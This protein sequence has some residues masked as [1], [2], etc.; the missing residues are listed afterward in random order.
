MDHELLHTLKCQNNS[1]KGDYH[2]CLKVF[3]TPLYFAGLQFFPDMF[4]SG[5]SVDMW[6]LCMYIFIWYWYTEFLFF[7]DYKVP[8]TTAGISKCK[9]YCAKNTK[10]NTF[11]FN[12][13]PKSKNSCILKSKTCKK[14][15]PSPSIYTY[16]RI[17][18]KCKSSI[19]FLYP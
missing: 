16:Q 8:K 11:T 14:S 12:F 17:I 3:K 18:N 19:T 15:K 2:G 1:K 4:S 10:C 7:T 5:S 9:T 13:D 6:L